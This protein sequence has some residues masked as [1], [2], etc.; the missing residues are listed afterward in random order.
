MVHALQ[1]VGVE[2]RCLVLLVTMGRKAFHAAY[3]YQ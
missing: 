3:D 2:D 1:S